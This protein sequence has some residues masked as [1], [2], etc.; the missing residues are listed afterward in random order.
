MDP[1]I[2]IIKIYKNRYMYTNKWS[3]MGWHSKFTRKALFFRYINIYKFK[4]YIFIY[5][6]IY[7]DTWT[8][9]KSQH[10]GNFGIMDL[11]I[12]QTYENILS[13]F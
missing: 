5:I 8:P 2:K 6:S 11:K 12:F 7:T 3:G 10:I 4:I 13:N 9:K 1:N